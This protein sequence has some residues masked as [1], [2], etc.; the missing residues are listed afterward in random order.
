[1]KPIVLAQSATT[2]GLILA[3]SAA[4]F[5]ARRFTTQTRR[6]LLFL[7]TAIILSS[8]LLIRPPGATLLRFIM[9]AMAVQAAFRLYDLHRDS[10]AS[11]ARN[12]LTFAAYAFNPFAIALRRV[13]AE[14][15][16]PL[17]HNLTVFLTCTSLG[18]IAIALTAFVFHID[19]TRH[20]FVL[21]HC[22]KVIS[23]MLI[24]QFLLN[25]LSAAFRLAG[26]PATTF[27]GNFFLSPT[28]AEFW[29]RYNRPV[30]QFFRQHVF[31]AAG[32]LHHPLRAILATFTL[33]AVIH[34]YAFD[35]AARRFLGYQLL[36]FLL[37]GLASALTLRLR[38]RGPAP[39]PAILLTTAFNLT[40]AYLFF[41]SMNALVPFYTPRPK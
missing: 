7:L 39:L 35:I 10:S 16:K 12:C 5:L 3:S 1:M 34:E 41:L 2:I 32:G 27:A 13:K 20:P 25:G 6:L 11:G 31:R 21:E 22:T 24:I 23:F 9:A 26:V 37:H 18:G 14:P 38:P 8:P 40:T 4:F 33:S 19:W 29:R 36:F 15:P 28:P 30:E 17:R